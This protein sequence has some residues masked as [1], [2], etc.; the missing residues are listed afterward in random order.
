MQ[1]EQSMQSC[2]EDTT[3]I[4]ALKSSQLYTLSEHLLFRYYS[5]QTH[6][7]EDLL[8]ESAETGCKSGSDFLEGCETVI[9]QIRICLLDIFLHY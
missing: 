1:Q 9:P 5:E 3:T 4:F 6:T 7:L 2:L 8:D